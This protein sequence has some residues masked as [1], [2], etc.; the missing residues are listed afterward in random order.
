MGRN[1]KSSKRNPVCEKLLKALGLY[2]R[3]LKFGPP[4]NRQEEPK[5]A[6]LAHSYSLQIQDDEVEKEQKP[7][8]DVND[9]FS[10]YISRA[11]RRLGSIS[12]KRHDW[13]SRGKEN[14]KEDNR[15]SDYIVRARNKLKATS[16]SVKR[17]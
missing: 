8:E 5:P 15:F 9:V 11:K 1:S 16:S 2:P 14:V 13:S 7:S 3:I 6:A 12:S 10:D 4:P 17:E